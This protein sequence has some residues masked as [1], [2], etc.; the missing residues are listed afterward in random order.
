MVQM[1]VLGGD[2]YPV[3]VMLDIE[4]L[5]DQLTSMM[6]IDKDDRAS[7]VVAGLLPLLLD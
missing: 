7:H 1:D 5:V 3:K 4:H 2:Y 6:I